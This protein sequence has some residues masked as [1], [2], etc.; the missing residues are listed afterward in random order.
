MPW[1]YW[2][3]APRDSPALLDRWLTPGARRLEHHAIDVGV[4]PE[5]AL[6]AIGGVRLRDVPIVGAL[7]NLRRLPYEAGM[8]LLRLFSTTP[9]LILEE[10]PGR[11][12]VFGVVGPF[13]KWRGGALPPGLPRTPEEF[14]AALADGRMAALGNFR[15]EPLATG[16]RIWT[17]TWVSAPGVAQAVAFTCYWLAVGPFS[18]WIRRMLLAAARRR[19]P[20]GGG[21]A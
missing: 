12:F 1:P 19:A 14:R 8:T 6:A 13:W 17:E 18:A 5:A 16:S 21:A 7:F 3:P 11:E 9:F 20:T 4:G 15:A 10:E 2:N